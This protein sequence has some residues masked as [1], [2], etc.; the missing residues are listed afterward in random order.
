VTGRGAVCAAGWAAE[1]SRCLPASCL[2]TETNVGGCGVDRGPNLLRWW[3][4]SHHY[5]GVDSCVTGWYV[6][7]MNTKKCD[8]CIKVGVSACDGFVL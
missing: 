3:L 6:W 8:V 1:F 5:L 7:E 4:V 2:Y